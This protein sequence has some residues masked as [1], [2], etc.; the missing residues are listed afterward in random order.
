METMHCDGYEYEIRVTE[1]DTIAGGR[2]GFVA[3]VTHLR[4][5]HEGRIELFES[6]F[7]QYHGE[8]AEEAES[9]ARS[10]MARWIAAQRRR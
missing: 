3:E 4:Q 1:A 5:H 6:T 9:R 7:G 10:G 2:Y 8:T